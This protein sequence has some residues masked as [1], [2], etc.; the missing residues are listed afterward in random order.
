MFDCA[1]NCQQD[2]DNDGICDQL[3]W[4]IGAQFCGENTYWDPLL[5]TCVGFDQCPADINEEGF[6]TSKDLLLFLAY[7]GSAC[8]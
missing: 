6:V 1:G 3:E 7:Y 2:E 5:L 4:I 8:D